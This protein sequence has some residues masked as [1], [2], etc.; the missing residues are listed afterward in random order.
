VW[1]SFGLA[2]RGFA[3]GQNATERLI[4]TA[5]LLLVTAVMLGFAVITREPHEHR[6][7]VLIVLLAYLA[8]SV[9]CFTFLRLRTITA[10][11]TIV[12]AV[13]DVSCASAIG[14]FEQGP[15]SP[16]FLFF[17][18]ALLT[19]AFRWGM[20]GA[21]TSGMIMVAM[22]CAGF[23]SAKVGAV[24]E[25]E[26][27]LI[28]SAELMTVAW[29][30]GFFAEQDRRNRRRAEI[31][32]GILARIQRQPDFLSTL[33]AV[34]AEAAAIA[35]AEEAM[36]VL[37]NERSGK[38]Y[39]WKRAG[40]RLRG[41]DLADSSLYFE[42]SPHSAPNGSGPVATGYHTPDRGEIALHLSMS[43]GWSGKIFLYHLHR[44]P[45]ETLQLLHTVAQEVAPAVYNVYIAR[46]LHQQAGAAERAR[47]ARELH[48]GIL[49]ELAAISFE[50]EALRRSAN[51]REMQTGLARIRDLVTTESLRLRQLI[52]QFRPIEISPKDLPAF[53]ER[54]IDR[55]QRE[56]GI[57]VSLIS[58]LQEDAAPPRVTRE[59]ARITQEALI[60]IRKHSGA[61]HVVIRLES[62]AHFWRLEV[63]DDGSGFDF[64]GRLALDEL[65]AMR[66]GP[67]VIKERARAI[68]AEMEVESAPG[69]GSRIEIRFPRHAQASAGR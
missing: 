10:A 1:S 57:A 35:R 32:N 11:M 29:I 67:I 27:L 50:A 33:R 13:A 53:L 30:A 8:F 64:S 26:R 66:K 56:T 14:V 54:V 23:V 37:R 4:S 55:F 46:Q 45:A 24:A 34:L 42:S 17:T 61:K 48:D 15:N 39:V 25:G 18:F 51:G 31:I 19:C 6:M 21:L 59:I 58:S 3:N 5:R 7:L 22:V 16:L 47:L 52:Q 12:T 38:S 41:R 62:T 36:L 44:Q 49:Q 28:S 68:R 69:Q 20:A 2:P 65:D 60:N 9:F 40:G 43:D 63:D